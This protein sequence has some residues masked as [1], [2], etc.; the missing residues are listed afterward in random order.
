METVGQLS[1]VTGGHSAAAKLV[2]GQ[3]AEMNERPWPVEVHRCTNCRCVE[4][5]D[6]S[7]PPD[8]LDPNSSANL[9]KP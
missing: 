8:P 9:Y 6:R 4:M 3:W 2:F 1:L 5:F 7:Q